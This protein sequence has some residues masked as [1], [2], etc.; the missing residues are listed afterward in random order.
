VGGS[1]YAGG[2]GGGGGYYGGGGG[3]ASVSGDAGGGGGGGGSCYVSGTDTT[4]G[5]ASGSTPANNTDGDYIAPAGQGGAGGAVAGNGETGSDGRVII[6]YAPNS[7][8]TAPTT[9]YSNDTSAQS[10]QT[11]PS[12][13]TDP[14]PAFS[15]IYNDPDSG[16]IANKY[17]VEVNTAGDFSGTVMWDSGASGTSMADAT[18]GSRCPDIIYAGATLAGSTIYYW[19]IRF[20]DDDNTEGEV[21]ATQNFTTGAFSATTQSWGENSSRDDYS[22]VTEDTFMDSG[23]TSHEEGTCTGNDAVRIGYRTDTGSRAMRSLIKFDLSGLQSLISSSSQITAAA[24]KVKIARRTGSNIDVDA[25]RVLKSWSEG[26]QCHDDTDL[27]A[28]EATWQYQSY[29]TAW[30]AGGADSAG[31]DRAASAD[32]TTTITGTGWFSW[33]VTQS[34]KDMFDDENYDGWVLK[35]QTESGDNWVAFW[36]SEDGTAAN[37]PYLEITYNNDPACGYAYKKAIT[38]DHAKVIGD[39]GD[40]VDLYDF[41]VV[42]KEAG[43]WLRNS[44]FTGGRIEN[45][46]GY[47][48]I[49]KDATETLTLAHEIEYYNTGSEAADGELVAWVKIPTL[50]Y[51]GN[52]VIYMYYGNSCVNSETQNKN[53]VWNSSYKIVQHLQETSGTHEDS[54]ANNNHSTAV[55]VATQGSATGKIDGADDFDGTSSQIAIGDNDSQ[56]ITSAI[57]IEAWIDPDDLTTSKGRI[58][59]KSNERYVLRT[60]NAHSGEFEAYVDDGTLKHA[61]KSGILNT[62]GYQYV[63]MTWASSGTA[64]PIKLYYNGSEVTNYTLQE[65]ATSPLNTSTGDLYIGSHGSGEYFNGRIDEVRISSVA[66][67]AGWIQTSF[68]NQNAPSAFYGL[69]TEDDDPLNPVTLL[70]HTSGQIGDQ[71]DGSASQDDKTLF[72]LRLDNKNA[73]YATIDQMVFH[74][75]D[76][77]GIETADLSDLKLCLSTS[78]C[79]NLAAPTVDITG[80][81]GTITFDQDWSMAPLFA[82]NYY[83]RGDV[84]DLSAYDTLTISMAP[85]DIT[86]LSGGVGGT[87]PTD[88]THTTDAPEPEPFQY[89]K[90]IEIDRTKIANPPTFPITFDAVSSAETLPAAGAAA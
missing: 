35:S 45:A 81:S 82:N 31:V 60:S 32:D 49:F 75:S 41:P 2:G 33:D 38:I 43:T 18:A 13:L 86:L 67:T 21:S 73:S 58:V 1:G 77:S 15:A 27:D 16:D 89:R 10:G 48:I 55:T 80:D 72:R 62:S 39:G 52:T 63:A 79:Y 56:H 29:S 4:V 3:G 76:V 9:P 90:A 83:L 19:R 64:Q 36:S 71:F 24:L 66:R 78:S 44:G 68:N 20:W 69:G 61:Q 34:V 47:D 42:I 5:Q 40:T 11:N 6:L 8:P 74:L 65:S 14:T 57:T 17:R 25:F 84:A 28:G 51:N 53:A 30:T 70:E 87:A 54:T 12:G 26:D 88:A 7:V 59:T 37:R 50:D 46:S 23:S 22:A 85:S